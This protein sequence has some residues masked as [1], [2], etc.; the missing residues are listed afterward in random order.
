MQSDKMSF[1]FGNLHYSHASS[2]KDKTLLFLHAFHS[3]AMS[4]APLCEYLKDKYNIVCLDF[5]GHGLSTHV[6]CQKYSWS[7]SIEGF[8]EILIEFIDQLQLSNLYIIGDSVGG[9]CAVRAMNALDGLLGLI[10]MGTAQAR[11]IEMVFSL[12]HQTKALE[13][14]FQ[15]E[16]SEKEDEIVAAA[17]V[18]PNL[19]EGKNFKQMMYD[20]QRTDPDCR[21]YFAKQIETQKWVDELQIIQSSTVPLIYILGADDGFIDSPKYRD[22]LMGA[23]I[24]ESQ[25]YLI[26]D[27]RHMPQLDNPEAVSEIVSDFIKP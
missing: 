23:G 11:S 17:Y 26:K 1:K 7:Y 25:I 27:A 12:H 5:P 9:N 4:Y 19:N 2:G 16:R 18:D 13:L 15:K 14:L 22:V 21:E 10:L 24:K 3:S 8:T 6:D 20:I